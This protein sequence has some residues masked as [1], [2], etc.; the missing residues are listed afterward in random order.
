MLDETESAANRIK[1][2]EVLLNRGF[3]T[4]AS[5]VQLQVTDKTGVSDPSSLSLEDLRAEVS[6]QLNMGA[7]E[8]EML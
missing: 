2:A 5:M 3:G 7:I 8:G 4:P 6:R 1:A